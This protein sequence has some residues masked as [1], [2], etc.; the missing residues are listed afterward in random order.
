MSLVIYKEP[1]KEPEVENM[2]LTLEKLQKAVGRYIEVVNIYGNRLV[3]I[4]NE[5]GVAKRLEPNVWLKMQGYQGTPVLGPIVLCGTD[6]ED[7]AG[8]KAV[9]VARLLNDLRNGEVIIR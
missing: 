8:L 5:D 7:F 9:E 3:M 4:D 6:G 2:D 1:G